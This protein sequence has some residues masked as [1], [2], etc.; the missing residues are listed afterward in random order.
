MFTYLQTLKI[1]FNTTSFCYILVYG[2]AV[3]S[4]PRKRKRTN[5]KEDDTSAEEDDNILDYS[6]DSS[7]D[8]VDGNSVI[9]N[10]KLNIGKTDW[11]GLGIWYS[12]YSGIAVKLCL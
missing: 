10:D 8:N 5:I 12:F 3:R 6:T 2:S 9:D 11:D 4:S 1:P 7:S